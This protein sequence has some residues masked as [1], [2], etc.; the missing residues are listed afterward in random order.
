MRPHEQ[1]PPSFGQEVER[2][3]DN[4]L[5][6][7]YEA[8][9]SGS[10]PTLT[11]LIRNDPQILHR[12]SLSSR[13][14]TPLHI[15][16]L[17]GH[18]DFTKDLLTRKPELASRL[19]SFKCSPLHLASAEGH[20]EIVKALLGANKEVCLVADEEGRIPLHLAAMRGKVEVIQEL[21]DAQHDSIRQKLNGS[22]VLHLCVQFNQLEA[23]KQL[24]TLVDENQLLDY[25]D[26]GGNTIL[27]LAVMLRQ[28]E[29]ITFLV[30][31]PEIKAKINV[32]NR[33]GLSALDLLNHY[34]R[35]S[36]SLEIGEILIKAGSRSTPIQSQLVPVAVGREIQVETVNSRSF[37]SGLKGKTKSVYQKC[38]SYFKHR[39]DWVEEM[40]GTLML[41]ATLT[42]TISFQVATNPPGGVWQQDYTNTTA[43]MFNCSK[44][45]GKCVAGTAVLAYVFP[46]NYLV[47]TIVAIISFIASLSVVLLA[48]S[49]LPLKNKLCTWLMT[50]AMIIAITFVLLTLVGAIVVV[51]PDHIFST[52]A[53]ALDVTEIIWIALVGIVAV[54]ATIRL[55]FWLFRLL[56]K[57]KHFLR[58]MLS[59]PLR[60]QAPIC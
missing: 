36:K 59:R 38:K 28:L 33:M 4:K 2:C 3:N 25:T 40:Q 31:V 55:L 24:V 47:L 56:T 34:P 9:L 50:I 17:S 53:E 11:M 14:E 18:L 10:L 8:A 1:N 52:I 15:S 23:L 51:T 13:P 29:T 57:L 20:T 46:G 43:G 32:L 45:Y 12:A 39:S 22:T 60:N 6:Q 19:D 48:I 21:V 30:S 41:V 16:A 44:D 58:K 5:L 54:F 27:H 49:G 35:D 37:T 26:H 7:L 42:A